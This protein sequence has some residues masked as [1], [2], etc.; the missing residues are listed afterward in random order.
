MVHDGIIVNMDADDYFFDNDAFFYIEK[1]FS[2]SKVDAVF[3]K[4]TRCKKQI[5]AIQKNNSIKKF[6]LLDR[7]A[8]IHSFIKSGRYNNIHSKAFKPQILQS[9]KCKKDIKLCFSEDRLFSALIF[10]ACKYIV[11]IDTPIYFYRQNINSETMKDYSFD[12]FNDQIYVEMQISKIMRKLNI[13]KYNLTY[14][15]HLIIYYNLYRIYIGKMKYCVK[16]EYAKTLRNNVL[17]SK[18]I[19]IP[20]NNIFILRRII[21]LLFRH[22]RYFLLY[23][24]FS[25]DMVLT[26]INFFRNL[27]FELG[28]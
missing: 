9:V 17:V 15:F 25:I 22:N 3:Y 18:E 20:L 14:Q 12:V 8:F 4:F 27:F 13:K 26:K 21:L 6:S 24:I 16:K 2:D 28:F 10:N 7:D 5:S 1:G 19:K 11:C 23:I